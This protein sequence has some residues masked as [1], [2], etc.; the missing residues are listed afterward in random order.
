ML[1]VDEAVVTA[2][3]EAIA[4]LCISL[5]ERSNIHPIFLAVHVK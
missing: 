3:N 4:T 1:M 5:L 2:F